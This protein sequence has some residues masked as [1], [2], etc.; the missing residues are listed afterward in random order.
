ML[1]EEKISKLLSKT[2]D[3]IY[4]NIIFEDDTGGFILIFMLLL[5]GLYCELLEVDLDQSTCS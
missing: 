1:T 3:F 2:E 5:Y 4:S